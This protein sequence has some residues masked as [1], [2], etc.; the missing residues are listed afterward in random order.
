MADDQTLTTERLVLRPLRLTDAE[1]LFLAFSRPEAM[2]FWHTPVHTSVAETTTMLQDMLHYEGNCY[3]TIRLHGN[4]QAL[5]YTGFLGS[6]LIPGMGY[7]IHPDYWRQGYTSEAVRAA[8]GYGFQTLGFERVELWI[9]SGNT[10]SQ[11]L[12]QRCG[13]TRYGELPVRWSHFEQPHEMG[14]YGLRA[15]EWSPAAQAQP[16]SWVR[17]IEPVL[18]ARN[19]S[20]TIAFYRDL[21]GFTITFVYG[22]PP[23]HAGV[24]RSEW[25]SQPSI[26]LTQAQGEITPSGWLYLRVDRYI[27]DLYEQYRTHGVQIVQEIG[28]RPWGRREFTIADCNG[29]RLRF[30]TLV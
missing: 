7:L 20:E 5:G 14:V 4:Q 15:G 25:S 8:L 30:G 26:Q 1:D 18:E 21:L 17:A 19:L 3:W 16:A 12:A 28:N 9:H 29:H 24:S 13:F 10:A 23:Q 11:R 27:D 6:T 2:R 22:N